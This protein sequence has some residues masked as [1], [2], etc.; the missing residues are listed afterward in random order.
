MKFYW[1][2]DLLTEVNFFMFSQV[3]RLGESALTPAAFVGLFAVFYR[4]KW[5]KLR[6]IERNCNN[7]PCMNPSVIPER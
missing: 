1:V 5:D 7:L 4:G 2:V 6:K 3:R